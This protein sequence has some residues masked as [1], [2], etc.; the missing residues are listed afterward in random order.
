MT[1]PRDMTGVY[2]PVVALLLILG[3][4]LLLR[5]Q[6]G[7]ATTVNDRA[8]ENSDGSADFS[9]PDLFFA[10]HTEIRTAEDSPDY[11]VNYRMAEF[12]SALAAR[13]KPG[14]KLDWVER[15]PA[16]VPGRTR[17]LLVDPDDSNHQTW[18]AG[19]VSGGLWK[20][21]DEGRSWQSLT[22]HLPNLAVSALA[23]ADSDRDVIYMGTGEGFANIASVAG[24]GIFK[25][26]DRGQ[27]WAQLASTMEGTDFLFVNRL[28]VDPDDANT[29]LAA[30]LRG[31]FRTIDG[32]SS[33]EQVYAP[34]NRLGVQD[35]AFCGRPRTS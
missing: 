26:T 23:M 25:S 35:L 10:Y 3:A 28:V 12:E 30:T 14:K 4:V 20:T 31:I 21:M 5:G 18:F 22:D 32:G 16:N 19:S 6:G 8:L 34:R 27:S 29:V 11:P 33:W 15:G 7:T 13:K 24:S 2:I 17:A 1:S 9:H